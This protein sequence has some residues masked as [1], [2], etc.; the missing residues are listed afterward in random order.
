MNSARVEITRSKIR[1][2]KSNVETFEGH[3]CTVFEK[4]CKEVVNGKLF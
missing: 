4:W 3:P 2:A 1:E